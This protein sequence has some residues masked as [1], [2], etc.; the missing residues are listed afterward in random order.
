[1]RIFRLRCESR[2]NGDVLARLSVVVVIAMLYSA[3]FI[4]QW[5]MYMSLCTFFVSRYF[6]SLFETV[7]VGYKG[8]KKCQ[9]SIQCAV[10]RSI[11]M[12]SS[13]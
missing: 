1:M 13:G 9:A 10:A 7:R 5:T 2:Y 4:L 3:F 6:G 11:S 8:F 12:A